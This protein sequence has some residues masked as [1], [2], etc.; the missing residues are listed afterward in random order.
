MPT[1]DRVS[2][3]T[4]KTECQELGEL[5]TT[6]RLEMPLVGIG[7][8]CR[9]RYAALPRPRGAPGYVGMRRFHAHAA[10]RGML[11]WPRPRRRPEGGVC[12]YL[13]AVNF[14]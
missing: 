7:G 14:C 3:I 11:V 12:G 5:H 13:N 2:N 8:V 10:R 1:Y 4:P 9:C 6:A